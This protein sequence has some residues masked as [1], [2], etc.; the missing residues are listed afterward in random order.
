MW[1]T[2]FF[3]P[4]GLVYLAGIQITFPVPRSIFI[5]VNQ[6]PLYQPQNTQ[7]KPCFEFL[8]PTGSQGEQTHIY[9]LLYQNAVLKL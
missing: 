6:Q 8:S 5:D 2:F 3:F 9:Q 4:Q 1:W 7:F